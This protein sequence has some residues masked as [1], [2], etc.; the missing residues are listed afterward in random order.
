MKVFLYVPSVALAL[1]MVLCWGVAQ[2]AAQDA[3]NNESELIT[4]TY[5]VRG[6]VSDTLERTPRTGA[7]GDVLA[8]DLLFGGGLISEHPYDAWNLRDSGEEAR[9]WLDAEEVYV[10]VRDFVA[11]HEERKQVKLLHETG[12]TFEVV[13]PQAV[14]DRIEWVL[15]AMADITE[16]RVGI[17][18]YRLDEAPG[19]TTTPEE[20]AQAVKG[21]RL[22]GTLRGGLGEPL[23]LQQTQHRSYVADYDFNVA[24]DASG[25]VPSVRDL[26]TGEEFVLGALS[27]PD[28]R[29]WLQGWHAKATEGG[30]RRLETTGGMVELPR[31]DYSYT[32]VSAV[33]D[34]GGGAILDAGEHGRFLVRASCSRDIRNHTLELDDG[35]RLKL[36]NC[37]PIMRGHGLGGFWLMNPNSERVMNDGAFAQ[38]MLDDVVD[39][40]YNDSAAY[41]VDELY[42]VYDDVHVVG[43]YLGLRLPGTGEPD[44]MADAARLEA[45]IHDIGDAPRMVGVRISAWE[46]ADDSGIPAG[47]LDGR[48][49]DVD[50]AELRTLAG[51]GS[52]LD[53]ISAAMLDQRTDV[54][55]VRLSA[56]VRDYDSVSATGAIGYDPVIATLVTGA[57]VRWTAR[58][59]GNGRVSIELRS[60]ITAGGHEF[61]QVATGVGGQ[62]FSIERS[63]SALTQARFSDELHVGER[64]AAVSPGAGTEGR[65][66]VIVVERVE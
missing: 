31:V 58:D 60:G 38:V 51:D 11:G 23:V 47:I 9:C 20:T 18:V 44:L 34:N 21:K 55:D 46:I 33:V 49:A 14:H 29:V 57:Q 36:I 12:D 2:P 7:V 3:R 1:A 61:E 62:G 15:G 6:L 39:G 5:D 25:S 35:S 4:R 37:L 53:R 22:V 43:P 41:M 32:P 27:L 42:S 24:T 17:T 66:I 52:S 65:L 54:L 59:A 45:M 48:P 64:M 8:P 56:H 16:A 28:G 13:A 40:P 19:A 30:M 50:L 63:S 10:I 26:N